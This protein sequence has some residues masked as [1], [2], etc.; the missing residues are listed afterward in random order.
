MN[1]LLHLLIGER[2]QVEDG[3]GPLVLCAPD[4]RRPT[5]NHEPVAARHECLEHKVLDELLEARS[6]VDAIDDDDE[7]AQR[8]GLLQHELALR[9]VLGVLSLN[10]QPEQVVLAGWFPLPQHLAHVPRES[11]H[12]DEERHGREGPG[13][14]GRGRGRPAREHS[15]LVCELQRAPRLPRARTR[16][17]QHGR[18]LDGAVAVARAVRKEAEGDVL[19]LLDAVPG[20]AEARARG[21][22]VQVDV[23]EL[24]ADLEL[25][26]RDRVL[27]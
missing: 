18:R 9:F 1:H 27:N 17:D 22:H 5:R 25:L 15:N 24:L 11:L 12:E 7:A 3:K 23:E 8:H 13:V 10:V 20:R 19:G 4:A 2:L 6:L 14:A 16:T 26:A 21:G